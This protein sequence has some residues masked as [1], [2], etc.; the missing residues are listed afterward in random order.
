MANYD[1]RF[2]R[3]YWPRIKSTQQFLGL[4]MDANRALLVIEK[5]LLS[6]QLSPIERLVFHESWL[7]KTYSE[8]AKDSAY[9]ADYIKEVGSQLWR[10]ISDALGKKVTKKNVHIVLRQY[11]QNLAK[12]RSL[13]S[14]RASLEDQ[15]RDT[16]YLHQVPQVQLE[17]PSGPVP[18]ESPFY[19]ERPP[20]E[21]FA[22]T[23]VRVPG[24]IIR[25]KAPRQFGKS[26]LIIRMLDYAVTQNYCTVHLDFQTA[27]KNVF[28]S[29]DQFLRW[30]SATISRE[31]QLE[32]RLDQYWDQEIGSRLSCTLYFQSYVLA[33]IQRPLVLAF[34]EVSRLFEYPEI[35]EACLPLL[36][37]WHEKAKRGGIWQK[38]RFVMAYSTEVYVPL[39]LSQSPFNVGLPLKLPPFTLEQIQELARR[40]QLDWLDDLQV[41]QLITLLGGHPY[42]LQLT[43]YHL[44]RQ[45]MTLE[46]ILS[47]ATTEAGI[48]SDHLR[49]HLTALCAEPELSAIFQQ[50]VQSE[51]SVAINPIHA[52][53]LNSMGLLTL[54]N[55]HVIPSCELYRLYFREYLT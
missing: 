40:C 17:F 36:R 14:R 44:C 25:I 28:E 29:P 16:H 19:I 38:V 50:V 33:Q 21:T 49:G 41:Q 35:A 30:F 46:Q 42:L 9:G 48:Y 5:T 18:L 7:G 2:R 54:E 3:Q 52:Y 31:L 37:L 26:S 20:I 43:F 15:K 32:S 6:R 51:G 4:Y 55:D 34:N 1:Q 24:N 23:G 53:K 22:Y 45:T 11:P 27:D 13:R 10:D 12:R 8:M 39:K 47:Q